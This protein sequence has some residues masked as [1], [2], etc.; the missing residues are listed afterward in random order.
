MRL[1]VDEF[2]PLNIQPRGGK[3]YA[4]I[5]HVD[6]IPATYKRT[7]GI[8]YF[9]GVYDLQRD[10]LDGL[11]ADAKGSRV[12]LIFLQWL[13]RRHRGRGTLHVVL[14]NLSSH[15]TEDVLA[16]AKAHRIMFYLTP[17]N[18]SWLNRIEC[19]FTAMKKFCLDNTNYQSHHE[20][21]AAMRNYLA[22]RNRQR[23]ISLEDWR[24]Y[25]RSRKKV[26]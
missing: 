15:L 8:Q 1:C 20:Q 6:R 2:G 16:Y 10:T 14:D 26:A 11:F 22:W 4:K 5:G 7:Q 13:R 12:F 17:T 25:Q 18:A 9:F 21:Q 3:H 23:D 24:R 19:H